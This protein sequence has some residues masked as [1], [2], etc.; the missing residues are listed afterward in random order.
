MNTKE[1]KDIRKQLKNV[2]QAMAP[3]VLASEAGNHMYRELMKAV[4]GKLQQ[5]EVQ[6]Q[7]TL[8]KIDERSQDLQSYAMRQI[9]NMMP[10]PAAQEGTKPNEEKSEPANPSDLGSPLPVP[11]QGYSS[12]P[13]SNQE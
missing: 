1:V 7:E 3:T 4:Q 2:A 5:I 9:S 13:E 12:V 11:T 8:K 10:F 6:V